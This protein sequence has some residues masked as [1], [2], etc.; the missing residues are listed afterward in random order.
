MIYMPCI[1][2]LYLNQYVSVVIHRTGPHGRWPENNINRNLHFK[3]A[4]RT[5]YS[6]FTLS[7]SIRKGLF[8][9]TKLQRRLN[10]VLA[11]I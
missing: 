7:T 5:A 1:R 10:G 11:S 4:T 9:N 8:T 2:P 6:A 3:S